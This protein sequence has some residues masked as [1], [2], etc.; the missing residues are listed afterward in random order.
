M[1]SIFSILSAVVCFNLAMPAAAQL[2]N[3][4]LWP[5]RPAELEQARQLLYEHKGAEAAHIL[6]PFI[7]EDGVTGSEAR[8]ITG[9]VNVPRYL[10][11]R[12]PN[13]KIY[14]VKRGDTIGRVAATTK[15]P[16]DILMMLNGMV[17]LSGLKIGQKLVYIPMTLRMEIHPAQNELSVWDKDRLVAD[18]RI[19]RH[20]GLKGIEET[21]VTARDGYL[22]SKR[23]PPGS[24][25]F[26][27]SH[28]VLRLENGIVI[29]AGDTS[30]PR[31]V[32]LSQADMNE[33]G[34]LMAVSN[35]VTIHLPAAK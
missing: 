16:I 31:S 28:R 10:S 24:Y 3:Y 2:N 29:S 1:K 35:K 33:L 7:K 26:P 8:R 15:C 21:T 17:E 14:T 13:A 32:S 30:A 19:V 6:L 27:S 9:L 23:V 25:L 20:Q 5:R 18:Y 4:S 11:R 22:H 12:H 34:R